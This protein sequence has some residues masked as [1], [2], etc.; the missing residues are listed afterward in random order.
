MKVRKIN[1]NLFEHKHQSDIDSFL[2]CFV[3]ILGIMQSLNDSD[4]EVIC[5]QFIVEIVDLL[6]QDSECFLYNLLWG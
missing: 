5:E 6:V 4:P 1:I 2:K 3:L